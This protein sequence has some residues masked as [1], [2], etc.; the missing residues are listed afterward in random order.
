MRR[1]AVLAAQ[2]G[3]VHD[4][5]EAIAD[6]GRANVPVIT[7][8]LQRTISVV[9]DGTTDGATSVLV[10]AGGPTAPYAVQVHERPPNED[11]PG[12]ET[13]PEGARGSRFLSRAA[14]FNHSVLPER[15]QVATREALKG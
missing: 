1:R 2:P 15:V 6:R 9:D 3:A 5:A 7:G 8:N 12:A 10:V 13:T 4:A 11:Q 14:R